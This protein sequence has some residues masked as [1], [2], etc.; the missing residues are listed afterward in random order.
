[1]KSLQYHQY[2]NCFDPCQPLEWIGVKKTP[3]EKWCYLYG[4]GKTACTVVALTKMIR[5]SQ[6]L[7]IKHLFTLLFF[8]TLHILYTVYYH[9]IRDEFLEF[10]P[11]TCFLA[12]LVAIG[13]KLN[14]FFYINMTFFLD[15]T[16]LFTD[17]LRKT[18]SAA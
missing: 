7:L 14:R 1:M 6:C 2:V 5:P 18:K 8:F 11:S 16:T 13:S 12:P 4:I 10:L 9:L 3:L 17:A 15:F